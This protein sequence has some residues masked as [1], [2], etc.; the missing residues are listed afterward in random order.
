LWNWHLA[1]D[2]LLHHPWHLS[3]DFLRHYLWN[4]D[5]S[6][7]LLD[8]CGHWRGNWLGNSGG[9]GHW[10]GKSH[11]L[12]NGLLETTIKSTSDWGTDG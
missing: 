9:H 1:D 2:F 11:W 7:P 6:L 12:S 4:F 8:C 5:H 10:L 3:D